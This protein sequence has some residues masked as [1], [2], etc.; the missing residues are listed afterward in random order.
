MECKLMTIRELLG[1]SFFIPDYQRGYRWEENE[2]D[3][4]LKD[5]MAFA[6]RIEEKANS[7]EIYCLQPLVV[8]KRNQED[9]LNRIKKSDSISEIEKLLRGT[10]TVVDGQQRLTTLFLI[11]RQLKTYDSLYSIEYQ[12]RDFSTE[13]LYS[14]TEEKSKDNI[15][16]YHIYLVNKEIERWFSNINDED[17]YLFNQVLLNQVSF[18]WYEI[19]QEVD[20]N[21]VFTRL[22]IGKIPLTDAELIK[23]LFLNRQN[24]QV[25]EKLQRQIAFEWDLMEKAL[26]D[27][28]F[29]LFIHNKNYEKPTRIDF[30][31]ELMTKMDRLYLFPDLHNDRGRPAEKTMRN[32]FK[33]AI[34]E[35]C[36]KDKHQ[37]FRYFYQSFEQNGESASWINEKW[38]EIKKYYQ[39]FNEWYRDYE[40]YHYVGFLVT[41]WD[42]CDIDSYYSEWMKDNRS[43]FIKYLKKEIRKHIDFPV[44]TKEGLENCVFEEG[45]NSVPKTKCRSVLLLH[46]IETIISQNRELVASKKY[47]CPNFNKFP[48][49]LYNSKDRGFWQVEHIRPNAGDNF[50]SIESKKIYLLLSKPYF[51]GNNEIITAID[52]YVATNDDDKD[53]FKSIVDLIERDFEVSALN[54][55]QKNKIWNYVLLDESTNKEYSNYIFPI[56][57]AF[58]SDKEQG[59]KVK[60]CVRDGKI[61][62][63]KRENEV[64]FILPCT[65]NVF[66]KF[67]T[68]HPNT[69][70]NWTQQDAQAYLD[71][72]ISKLGEFLDNPEEKNE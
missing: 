22:N 3:D 10:W 51:E 43:E 1:M 61:D 49:H 70:L 58:I 7:L 42:N 53:L 30:I 35:K 57:R 15:D 56:K 38:N 60:Y 11:M 17:K 72:M 37:L 48:F 24:Q 28:E 50:N 44:F 25:S 32:R 18:I 68:K 69:L 31:L 62:E 41:I 52:K 2:V 40:I 55:S 71:D 66:S 12:T 6:K 4:L 13:Y 14:P 67:Y 59:Y 34:D 39:V 26:Q 20:E 45:E 5:I 9:L 8:K 54:E 46:N 64:A 65:K 33:R 23:A 16:F 29:W 36:G 63:K 27:D 21:A 47:N 19:D